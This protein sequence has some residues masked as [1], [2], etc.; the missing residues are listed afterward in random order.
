MPVF[1]DDIT[2]HTQTVNDLRLSIDADMVLRGQ[3]IDPV[4]IRQKR[5]RLA[6]V[7]ERAVELG[8]SLIEPMVACRTVSVE[9]RRHE[10]LALVG[11]GQLSGSLL[12]QHL[13]PAQ[14][15]TLIVCTIGHRL[16][17]CASELLRDDPALGLALDSFGS[18]AVETLGETL[19]RRLET[20]AQ[21]R[22][23]HASVPLSPGMIGWPV[24]VGQSQI[25]DLLDTEAIG[26]TL[27]DRAMM[28]PHKSA[29]MILGLGGTPFSAGRT[30]DFCALRET[31]RYQD[32][33][34][35]PGG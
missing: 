7:A 10:R 16:E 14:R 13:A 23:Q 15:I 34:A 2:S 30:C 21:Q 11:G 6:A 17:Q 35:H 28:I 3:G 33:Y 18:V 9:S 26:V 1:L 4:V 29:S 8:A 31:C 12:A 20:E 25:F 27:N 19:C 32:H 24:E 5:P 22:D